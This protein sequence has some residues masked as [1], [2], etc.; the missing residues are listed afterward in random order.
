MNLSATGISS[1]VVIAVV[2]GIVTGSITVLVFGGLGLMAPG[3]HTAAGSY[4][5]GSGGVAPVENASGGGGEDTTRTDGA[6][7]SSE[8]NTSADGP[9]IE[10]EV[11]EGAN[12][13][14]TFC[15]SNTITVTNAGNEKATGVVRKTTV[16]AGDTTIH[17]GSGTIGTIAAGESIQ[18]T[19]EIETG[20]GAIAPVQQNGGVTI[21]TTIEHDDGSG[22]WR[23]RRSAEVLAP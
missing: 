11:A 14:G 2:S 12:Q 5:G 18:K 3:G 23:T 4:G 7:S 17:E 1:V 6:S 22:T 9:A 13:C 10:F 20:F 16:Y 8:A 21:V 15:R 19:V